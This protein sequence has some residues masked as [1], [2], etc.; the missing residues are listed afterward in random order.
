MGVEIT[1]TSTDDSRVVLLGE[2]SLDDLRALQRDVF[3]EIQSRRADAAVARS[4]SVTDMN[5]T[6]AQ[7]MDT[8][9]KEYERDSAPAAIRA[10]LEAKMLLGTHAMWREA[11]ASVA[12]DGS[13][14]VHTCYEGHDCG[15]ER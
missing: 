8:L 4:G 5:S 12:L 2:W 3:R 13:V 10:R 1:K 9:D 15:A 14:G 7:L 6:V 11:E